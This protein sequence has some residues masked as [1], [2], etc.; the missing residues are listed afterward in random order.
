MP[1]KSGKSKPKGGVAKSAAGP[2]PAGPRRLK[3]PVKLPNVWQLTRQAA[4]TLWAN[5][6][7]FVGVTLIY[8][9]LN[10]ILAQGFTGGTDVSSLKDAFNQV[11]TGHLGFIPTGLSIFAILATSAG[12][13][14]DQTAG[15]YQT[16]LAV[17]ASLALIWSLRQ[18]LSGNRPRARDAYYHGMSALIP[19]VLVLLVVGL[20]L[21]PLVIGSTLY[22]IVINTG[23]AVHAAEK[24]VSALLF[25]GL[26][27]L[28]LYMLSSS[29]FALYIVTL[30]DMTPFKALR[31]ARDLVRR[32]RWTVL[33]KILCLPVILLLIAL[34]VMLPIISLAAPMARWSFFVLTMFGLTAI[35]AY[36]YTLYRELLNE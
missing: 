17:I 9:F 36:M 14:T 23:I 24:A 19:F 2:A 33:R 27:L 25:A 13:N 26:G 8:G 20:Q 12:N 1:K 11:F 10:L 34:V 22:S 3:A 30:P 5:K 18:V 21:I 31:S 29:L 28:T 4:L 6:E 35:H 7:L 15:A 32:R 16:I